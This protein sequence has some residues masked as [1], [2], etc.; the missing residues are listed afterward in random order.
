M[1]KPNI[2]S[3]G[4]SALS[5]FRHAESL[6]QALNTINWMSIEWRLK[7]GED[8]EYMKAS[9][10][11]RIIMGALITEAYLK[12]LMKLR[13]KAIPKSHYL[14]SLFKKLD[15]K[16]K[17][18]IMK[19][20]DGIQSAVDKRKVESGF[21]FIIKSPSFIEVISSH[22]DSFEYWRY[23]YEAGDPRHIHEMKGCLEMVSDAIR[24][25]LV[26]LQPEWA[27]YQYHDAW[28]TRLGE[29][30]APNLKE[31]NDF[32]YLP[33]IYHDMRK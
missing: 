25:R 27:Q 9:D 10:S 6:R 5:A 17:S 8:F 32:F 19:E 26:T 15:R 21:P 7:G 33:S 1:N 18:E 29:E 16:D 11:S 20:F 24:K 2:D 22:N 4:F 12:A 31:N 28:R 30:K 13:G 14:Y 3:E 23:A